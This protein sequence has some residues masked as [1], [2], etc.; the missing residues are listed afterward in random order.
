MPDQLRYDSV[1]IFGND[2]VNTPNIDAFAREGT[3]FTNT[4]TQ[5]S[6]CSQSRCS[7]FTGQYPHVSGHRTLENLLKPWEPNIFRSMKEAGYHVAYLSPRGDFYAANATELSVNEYGFLTSQTLPE[8]SSPPFQADEDDI[9]NRVF[10]KGERNATQALD[11]DEVMV[12]GALQ[13]LERPPQDAPWVLFLPLL[14]PH[15]PFT[16][17]EPFFS[18]YDRDDMPLPIDREEMSG[19]QPRFIDTIH[20]A[21]GLDRATPELWREVKATYYGMISRLDE[22]FGRVVNAT[23]EQGL[24]N[25]T[26]TMFFTDHGEFLGD[27]GL[28]EKWPSG[29]NEQLTHEPLIVGGAGL[30]QGKA[31]GEMAEMVDLVPT[32]LQLASVDESYM[33][34]GKSLVDA[35]HAAGR[36]EVLPHKQHAYTEGGFLLNEEPLLE[37]GPF[38]YDIKSALQHNDTALVGKS[39]AVRDKEW[40]YVYRLYEPD[41]LYHRRNDSYEINNLAASP[42]HQHVRAKMRETV[43]QWMMETSDVIPWYKDPRAPDVHLPS[44][45]EQ[46]LGRGDGEL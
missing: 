4:Y 44:P 28:I 8:F 12:R 43:L 27:Y 7:I 5:A 36:G 11:Y 21:Y 23:K 34:F 1:G 46:Y 6:V 30:P 32:M 3:R 22:Q 25:S 42:D 2:L 26:V 14:F 29:V 18:M 38:P 33:H 35:M 40:T 15:C 39:V 9:L 16:V 10:Y 31:Y 37:Q 13:W 19:Y 41:E 20:A 17:E 24:W 45:Y